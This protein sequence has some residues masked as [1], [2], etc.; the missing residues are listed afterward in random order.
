MVEKER[1]NLEEI[2]KNDDSDLEK[3]ITSTETLRESERHNQT[4]RDTQEPPE[5]EP[6]NKKK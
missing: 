6:G 3:S 4:I 1:T 2:I 5:H